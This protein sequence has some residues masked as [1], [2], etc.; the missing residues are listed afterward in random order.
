MLL[1]SVDITAQGMEEHGDDENYDCDKVEYP[2]IQQ[3]ADL[4][5]EMRVSKFYRKGFITPFCLPSFAA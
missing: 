5:R 1:A 2:S 3:T 4:L